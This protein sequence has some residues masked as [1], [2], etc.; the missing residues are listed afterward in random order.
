MTKIV[1]DDKT[2]THVQSLASQD[3]AVYHDSASRFSTLLVSNL[4]LMNGGALLALPTLLDKLTIANTASKS[5]IVYAM[6]EFVSGVISA[7]ICGYASY[8]NYGLLGTHRYKQSYVDQLKLMYPDPKKLD[9]TS[10]S[11]L[12]STLENYQQKMSKQERY[13]WFTFWIGNISGVLS[14]VFFVVGCFSGRYALLDF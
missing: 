7:T 1:V 12:A 3:A 11:W 10:S 14:L 9:E 13:I 2:I 8:L 5:E 4:M 6:A